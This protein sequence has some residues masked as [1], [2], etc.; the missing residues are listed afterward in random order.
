M[1]PVK[2]RQKQSERPICHYCI[3]VK[4]TPDEDFNTSEVQVSVEN[5]F[6]ASHGYFT[7]VAFI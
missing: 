2:S 3:I 4:V 1:Y 7:C 6:G 5:S